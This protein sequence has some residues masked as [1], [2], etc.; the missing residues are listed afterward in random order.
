MRAFGF[1]GAGL[2]RS[3][4]TSRTR[5]SIR[6]PTNLAIRLSAKRHSPSALRTLARSVSSSSSSI[7]LA[8][9]LTNNPDHIY[10]PPP[11][12]FCDLTF[13]IEVVPVF[14]SQQCKFIDGP[15]ISLNWD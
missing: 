5:S 3:A 11:N 14:V 10:S 15:W 6:P 13:R 2:P 9:Q 12:H 7:K 1:G 8:A 4:R